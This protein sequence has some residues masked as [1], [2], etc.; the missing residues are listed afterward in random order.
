MIQPIVDQ[1][2]VVV[3]TID[4]ESDRV[5]AFSNRDEEVLG[6]CATNLFWLWR[7]SG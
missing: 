6:V 2:G 5:N 1:A 7:A 4:V 3:G